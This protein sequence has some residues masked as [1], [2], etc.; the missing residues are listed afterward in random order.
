[1]DLAIIHILDVDLISQVMDWT[2]GILETSCQMMT[3]TSMKVIFSIVDR[4]VCCQVDD[5]C[6]ASSCYCKTKCCVEIL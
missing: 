2:L 4:T 3:M 1:M 6:V 5:V